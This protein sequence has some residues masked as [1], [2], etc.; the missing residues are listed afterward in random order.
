MRQVSDLNIASNIPLP[1]PALMIHEI[2]R[3]DAQ[4]EFV[5]EARG[6][7]RDVLRH[8]DPRLLLV[9]GPCSI[10]DTRAGLEYATRLRGLIDAGRRPPS[11]GGGRRPRRGR[12]P[13]RSPPNVYRRSETGPGIDAS[14]SPG[15][16]AVVRQLSGCP[17]PARRR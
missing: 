7:I 5:A 2:P 6:Q 9:V 13:D 17:R 3:T 1:A 10:H 4:E 8:R 11:S 14:G 16:P 15:R 12:R